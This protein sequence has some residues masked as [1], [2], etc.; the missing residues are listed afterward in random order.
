VKVPTW[1]RDEAPAF[2]AVAGDVGASLAKRLPGAKLAFED[3]SRDPHVLWPVYETADA[4]IETLKAKNMFFSAPG[5]WPSCDWLG[6]FRHESGVVARLEKMKA[7]WD[8][9][10]RKDAA[11]LQKNGSA[12]A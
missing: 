4:E 12:Q 1:M 6:R 7:Q 5:L 11:K 9:V 10:A 3:L 8:A 2:A